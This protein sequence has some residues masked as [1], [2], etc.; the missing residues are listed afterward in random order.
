VRVALITN[1]S[2][3]QNR[4]DPGLAERLRQQLGERGT[5]Y[6]A[7]DAAGLAA[8]ITAVL[9]EPFDVLAI[10]G[11]DGTVHVV[12]TALLDRVGAAG[13]ASLPL[14]QVLP[15]GTMNTVSGS[16][17]V[18]GR[19]FGVYGQGPEAWLAALLAY[20]SVADVPSVRRS[21]LEVRSEPS[22]QGAQYGFLFGNGLIS[23]FLEVYYEGSE[24][25]PVKA[26]SILARGVLSA[27]VAGPMIRRLM[28]TVRV[29]V[30]ADGVA[31]PYAEYLCVAA[32]TTEDV[33]FGFHAFFEAPRSPGRMHALGIACSVFR[34]VL[35]LP[36]I[37]FARPLSAAD[38]VQG[39]AR[40]LHIQAAGPQV[41][42]IDGDFHRAG[43]ALTVAVGPELR[44]GTPGV[45]R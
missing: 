17:G 26:L 28:Q 43:P 10:N 23:N 33:G 32:G 29:Q 12:L 15:G 8:A 2:S 41:Y 44:L 1:P 21:V 25:T 19:R 4:R 36:R 40:T 34:F 31:W 39:S 24:P 7:G 13:W 45:S 38:V 27:L 6:K 16:Y 11:G 22:G 9:S 5:V 20:R 42:M 35:D 30:E 14:I 3:R 18:R 37:W